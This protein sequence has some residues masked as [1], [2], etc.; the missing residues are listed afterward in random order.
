MSIITDSD[1]K[2]CLLEFQRLFNAHTRV[3]KLIRKWNRFILIEATDTHEQYSM[4]VS[5]LMIDR[6]EDGFVEGDHAV[7]N[8]ILLQAET[9][10]LERIFS[11]DYN[12]ASAHIDGALAV[13]SLE[14]DKVKLEAIAM[15]I[16][17][18]S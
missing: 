13:F 11:G 14:K 6:I 10:V 18:L 1:L 5:D 9:E 12:P 15:V 3:K 7:D 2:K 8:K 16:W 4:V 17:G